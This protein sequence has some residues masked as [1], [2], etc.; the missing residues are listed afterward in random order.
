MDGFR[1]PINILNTEFD[2]NMEE[3]HILLFFKFK[4]I[5]VIYM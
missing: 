4:E 2:K 5:N 1:D 3:T